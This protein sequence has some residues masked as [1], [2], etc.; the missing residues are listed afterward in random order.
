MA[1]QTQWLLVM[2]VVTMSFLVELIASQSHNNSALQ[3][4]M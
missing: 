3:Q 4:G 1:G 2:L